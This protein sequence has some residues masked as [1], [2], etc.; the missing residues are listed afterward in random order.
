MSNSAGEVTDTSTSLAETP[1]ESRPLSWTTLVLTDKK[2]D[3]LWEKIQQFPQVFDDFSRG[4]KQMFINNLLSPTNIFVDISDGLG[5]AA[6]FG[7]RP[8]AGAVVHLVMF[9]RRLRG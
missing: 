5:L 8:R 6:G 3:E 7:V 2:I 9:D 4:N 1:Q